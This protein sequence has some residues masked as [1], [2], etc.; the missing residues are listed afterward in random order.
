MKIRRKQNNCLNCG[1]SLDSVYNFCPICGQENNDNNVSFGT[2]INDFF[3]N[4]FAF[5]SRF[6]KSAVPFLFKPGFLTNRYMEGKR[7]TY[8]HPLRVYLIVSLF[9]FFVC[10]LVVKDMLQQTSEFQKS[11]ED[12]ANLS[13][14]DKNEQEILKE[15]LSAKSMEDVLQEMDESGEADYKTL[16]RAIRE[17]TTAEERAELQNKLNS[18]MFDSLLFNPLDSSAIKKIDISGDGA[19]IRT[20]VSLDTSTSFFLFDQFDQVYKMSKNEELTEEEIIDSLSTEPITGF[21][22]YAATQGIKIMRAEREQVGAFIVKNLPIM[23]LILIPIFAAILKLLYIRRPF[24]YINHIIHGF[25]LHSFAYFIYGI[26]LIFTYFVIKNDGV[27]MFI[28]FLIFVLVTTYAYLSF[29]R[30]YKQGWFKTLVKFNMVGFIY[31][32]L[33]TT[34]FILEMIASFMMY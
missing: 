22:R 7:M 14:L 6:A 4:Y 33:I 18:F 26:T 1:A 10:T 12:T 30:V 29:L 13:F 20:S 24:L 2:L 28:N 3:S 11:V 5:D 9:Y 34:F 27:S 16:S 8:A 31:L 17:N 21:E 25:H 32:I 19:P 15:T 23:M